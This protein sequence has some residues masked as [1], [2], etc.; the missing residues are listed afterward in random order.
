MWGGGWPNVWKK[1]PL[2]GTAATHIWEPGG[3]VP[4]PRRQCR[5]GVTHSPMAQRQH[6]HGGGPAARPN[7][8]AGGGFDTA[9]QYTR[10]SNYQ[11]H[12]KRS[13]GER[14]ATPIGTRPTT[15]ARAYR[16]RTRERL[17]NRFLGR[18]SHPSYQRGDSPWTRL[19]YKPHRLRWAQ[20]SNN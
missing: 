3:C 8:S 4:P 7:G 9:L 15:T 17:P 14:A 10:K 6:A 5:R 19:S 11:R 13:A 18:A 2:L 16:T 20:Q 12:K 1:A